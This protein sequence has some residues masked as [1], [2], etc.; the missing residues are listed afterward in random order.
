[1]II[2]FMIIVFMIIMFLIILTNQVL[3]RLY[4]VLHP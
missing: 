4:S 1:M 2:M 3:H